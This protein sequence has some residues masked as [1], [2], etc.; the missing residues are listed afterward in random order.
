MT[1]RLLP[2]SEWPRLAGTLLDPAW[3][4][5]G[6]EDRVL[7]VEQDGQIVAC[8]ALLQRWHLEG[9]WTHPD[10]RGK[11]SVGRRL[12]AAT[13]A[14]V[15][16]M[17][18]REVLCMATTKEGRHLIEAFGQAIPLECEHFAVQVGRE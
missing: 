8:G 17:R 11:A 4:D 16:G 3:R 5:L 13:K 15:A 18:V 1:T 12:W 7:V 6:I 14:L 10:Y 9:F 2:P